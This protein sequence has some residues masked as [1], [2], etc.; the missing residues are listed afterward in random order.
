MTIKQRRHDMDSA[1]G[2]SRREC[3]EWIMTTDEGLAWAN[4][5][6]WSIDKL[7]ALS[8]AS[9]DRANKRR[10]A[11]SN[12]R[13]TPTMNSTERILKNLR[14]MTEAEFTAI[15][16]RVAKL[17]HPELSAARA[18][19]KLFEDPGPEGV[20]IRKCWQIAK[21]AN[22]EYSPMLDPDN[23][24]ADDD[25]ESAL[26]E[27]NALAEQERRKNPKLSKAQA[28]TRVFVDPSN[29]ALAKRERMQSMRKI[30]VAV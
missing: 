22:D 29:A 8:A 11:A 30:G 9:A 12:K 5:N 21:A 27:L 18:F 10:E 4:A 6:D 1:R 25:D 20:A 26:D 28:F 3:V 15:V 24:E 2:L 14:S 16:T 19:A 23:D 13:E 17:Q 7:V